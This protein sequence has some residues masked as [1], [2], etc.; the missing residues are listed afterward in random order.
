MKKS[1]RSGMLAVKP[2]DGWGRN[3]PLC[4]FGGNEQVAQ[5]RM[6]IIVSR[7]MAQMKKLLSLD[8]SSSPTNTTA[9]DALLRPP[10][11][12]SLKARRF[13]IKAWTPQV[14]RNIIAYGLI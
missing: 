7:Y 1:E 3:A 6:R 9:C 2:G 13:F 8:Q 12:G 10:S 14:I 11:R 5:L 4:Y